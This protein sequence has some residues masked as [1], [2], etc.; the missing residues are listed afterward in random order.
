[1]RRAQPMATESRAKAWLRRIALA[2]L[3]AGVVGGGEWGFKVY[4]ERTRPPKPPEVNLEG[5]DPELVRMIASARDAV[6]A[7]PGSGSAWGKLGQVLVANEFV[8]QAARCLAE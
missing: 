6:L 3:L 7:D 1:M 8:D 5:V 2:L 4:R